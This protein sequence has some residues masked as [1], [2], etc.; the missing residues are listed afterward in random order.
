MN[1]ESDKSD[2]SITQMSLDEIEAIDLQMNF[3]PILNNFK[4]EES[5]EPSTSKWKVYIKG[6]IFYLEDREYLNHLLK[7]SEKAI[8]MV[9][10][11]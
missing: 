1:T 5:S 3:G 4:T 9:I 2:N 11:N 10:T 8:K 7:E 6:E